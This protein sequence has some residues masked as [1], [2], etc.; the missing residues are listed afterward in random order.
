[1]AVEGNVINRENAENSII[2]EM[3]L[4][5]MGKN[6]VSKSAVINVMNMKVSYK[7]SRAI[8]IS[9]CMITIKIDS[10]S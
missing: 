8:L 4:R 2:M 9:A 1:M 3:S 10:F 7:L 5:N 6:A